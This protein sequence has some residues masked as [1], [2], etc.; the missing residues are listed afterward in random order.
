MHM[1]DEEQGLN[2]QITIMLIL[3]AL[4]GFIYSMLPNTYLAKNSQN[5][6]YILMGAL[7]ILI[8]LASAYYGEKH[9]TKHNHSAKESPLEK[10]FKWILPLFFT[11]LF[12]LVGTRA[13]II[14][15]GY[16]APPQHLNAQ[17][18]KH[19]LDE[20]NSWWTL[21]LGAPIQK[22]ITLAIDPQTLAQHQLGE[23]I[24]LEY[25]E[26][27]FSYNFTALNHYWNIS[28]EK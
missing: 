22:E 23:T 11:L 7:G 10:S 6:A 1:L 20:K 13:L 26:T 17:I 24:R 19:S 9:A 21:K 27:P 2:R 15:L 4:L 8:S 12:S 28:T 14:Y 25:R 18:I 16:K 5:T 3:N